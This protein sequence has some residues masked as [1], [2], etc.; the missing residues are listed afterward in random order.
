MNIL[1]IIDGAINA[2][3]SKTLNGGTIKNIPFSLANNFSKANPDIEYEQNILVTGGKAVE[4]A[5]AI[6]NIG[7]ENARSLT[8]EEYPAYY[9]NVV[10]LFLSYE[11]K[12]EVLFA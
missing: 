8:L 1:H 6:Q 9:V 12:F 2:S 5:Q 7:Y 4:V 10:G 3:R 11:K